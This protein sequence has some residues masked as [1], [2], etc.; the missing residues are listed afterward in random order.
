MC[1]SNS[2]S[3]RSLGLAVALVV[4]WPAAAVQ[5]ASSEVRSLEPFSAIALRGN[6]DLRVRQGGAQRVE[7]S[8]EASLLPSLQ[9]TV[10]LRDGVPTLVVQWARNVSMRSSGGAARVTLDVTALSA[11]S[12]AG[13]GDVEVQGLRTPAFA[14]SIAGSSNA[15]LRG[16]ETATL[17]VSIAGSGDVIA[18]GRADTLDIAIAGSGDV[19][20]REL[21]SET[22][23]VSIAGSGDASLRVTKT[24]AV[25]ISGSGDVDYA[26]G[27][28]LAHARVAGSGTVRQRP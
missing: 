6:I 11:L 2:W 25:S 7:V 17:R 22:A 12:A 15:L 18:S 14:L 24:L 21:A 8:A 4:A 16:L 23:S 13:S 1:R 19:R 9:T 20:A 27:A 28:S 5:A 10:E 3:R 26:G